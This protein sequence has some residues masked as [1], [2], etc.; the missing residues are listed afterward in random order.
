M[1]SWASGPCASLQGVILKLQ[2]IA[3]GVHFIESIY[4]EFS[5]GSGE[6]CD[7]SFLFFF[8]LHEDKSWECK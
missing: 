3:C 7:F 6:D 4:I 5:V 1:S 8:S 2:S